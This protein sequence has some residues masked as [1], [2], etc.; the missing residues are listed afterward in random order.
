MFDRESDETEFTL[1]VQP[2][3]DFALAR[4][5]RNENFLTRV[6][7]K[8]KE[9]FGF[10]TS[11]EALLVRVASEEFKHIAEITEKDGGFILDIPKARQFKPG[12]HVITIEV[13]EPQ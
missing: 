11:S 3:F 8:V 6:T 7:T 13:I 9:F 10:A 1:D 12:K 2:Q 5:K 4:E